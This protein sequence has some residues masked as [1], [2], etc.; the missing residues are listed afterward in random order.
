MSDALVAGFCP[1]CCGR[2]C[3]EA[4]RRFS[5]RSTPLVLRNPATDA[6]ALTAAVTTVFTLVRGALHAVNTAHAVPLQELKV[7]LKA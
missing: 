5:Q 7:A 1:A 4:I 6:A 2:S 3:R